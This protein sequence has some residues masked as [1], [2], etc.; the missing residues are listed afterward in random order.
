MNTLSLADLI[1]E[2]MA[3]NDNGDD[4]TDLKPQVELYV[5]SAPENPSVKIL[6]ECFNEAEAFRSRC[7]A[8]VAAKERR[9]QHYISAGYSA[10]IAEAFAADETEDLLFT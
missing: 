1:S 9:T 7:E 6:V 3:A 2:V 5:K 4:V 10:A 8:Y